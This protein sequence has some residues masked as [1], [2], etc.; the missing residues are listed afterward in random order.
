[1]EKEKIVTE[2]IMERRS[3]RKYTPEIPSREILDKILECGINAPNGQ[4]RQSWEI[5][6]VDNPQTMELI[7]KGM[8]KGN[9]D[10]N[11]ETIYGCFRGAPVM[12]F[13]ARDT[14]YDFSD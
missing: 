11:R 7:K 4:N 10:T 5:R 8:A 2:N 12:I 1:M 3:I 13:I 14:S 9:P 6:V